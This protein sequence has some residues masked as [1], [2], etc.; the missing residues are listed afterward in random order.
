[1]TSDPSR[2]KGHLERRCQGC[3]LQRSIQGGA[4]GRGAGDWLFFPKKGSRDKGGKK[5]L[6]ERKEKRQKGE[7]EE[8]ITIKQ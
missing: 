7:R 2:A 6:K 1:M 3:D 5:V 8:N 4:V